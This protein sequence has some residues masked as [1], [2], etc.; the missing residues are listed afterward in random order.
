[1]RKNDVR[2]PFGCSR[3][4]V[5]VNTTICALNYAV[6]P[7]IQHQSRFSFFNYVYRQFLTALSCHRSMGHRHNQS[8]KAMRMIAPTTRRSAAPL[9]RYSHPQRAQ[10]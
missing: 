7:C 2:F 5:V 1:M 6:A 3:N 8:R 4:F 9:S 10:K